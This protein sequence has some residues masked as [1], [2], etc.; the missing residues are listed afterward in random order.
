MKN[1]GQTCW[2]SAVIQSLFYLPAFRSLVLNFPP[3]QNREVE[4]L[5][6]F[7]NDRRRKI[8]EFML[9]LR[10][11]FA[12]MVGTQRK[13]VDPSRAVDILRGSIGT[14]NNQQN[15]DI[16][17]LE[18][19]NQQDVS[20]FTHIVLEWVEEAFKDDSVQGKAEGDMMQM[21]ADCEKENNE[22][23]DAV[24]RKEENA[25]NNPM[26]RLFY[27]KV[28]TEGR[29]RGDDFVRQE[30]FGQWPLQVNTFANIHESLENSLA[31]ESLDPDLQEAQ[32]KSGQERWFLRLPPV[33]FLELS[34]FH[35]NMERKTAEKIH[36]RLEFP[37]RIFMDRYVADNKAVTRQ[38]REEVRAL[39]EKRS[40]LGSR[41]DKFTT[42]GQS[43]TASMTL[44]TILQKTL[45]FAKASPI[46]P[47]V[48]SL[49]VS[50]LM[51]VDSPCG[52]PKMTPAPS[53]SNLAAATNNPL[54][55]CDEEMDV[56]MA[57][58]SKEAP[59]CDS[60]AINNSI[61]ESNATREPN[62]AMEPHPRFVSEAELRVLQ[63][64]NSIHF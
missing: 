3:P 25:D 16:L 56:E 48:A 50:N 47:T 49:A 37:E 7:G 60:S 19:N 6:E 26:S 63:V 14:L 44:P 58:S 36:N 20:E 55:D 40:Q 8:V 46:P 53:L 42:Y 30:A 21:D 17:T 18:T 4:K 1:V 45:D 9:E 5:Q 38:K 27:G 29:I 52:S 12:L 41:L 64:R 33:L 34:R 22:E 54:N 11:L 51:Q 28:L 23:K 13:Y 61:A 62:E 57:D 10:K 31:H 32:H 39:K 15:K 43:Q 2:F 24:N 59:G 35:Y